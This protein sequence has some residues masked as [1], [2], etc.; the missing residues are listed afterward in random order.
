[1]YKEAEGKKNCGLQI[2]DFKRRK[3]KEHRIQNA[4][5]RRR[6]DESG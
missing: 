1:L 6:K 2:A 5:L 4:E 3:N